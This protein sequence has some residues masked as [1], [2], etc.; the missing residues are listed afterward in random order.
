MSA[1]L[2]AFSHEPHQLFIASTV[3]GLTL[4]DS[5]VVDVP[6]VQNVFTLEVED[7]AVRDLVGEGALPYELKAMKQ[8]RQCGR[9]ERVRADVYLVRFAARARRTKPDAFGLRD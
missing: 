3:R 6:H 5:A 9:G 2:R 8:A 7:G 1:L 4:C